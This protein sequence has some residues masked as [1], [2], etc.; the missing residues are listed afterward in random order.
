[1]NHI[2]K[3]KLERIARRITVATFKSRYDQKTKTK[4][5][6]GVMDSVGNRRVFV[7]ESFKRAWQSLFDKFSKDSPEA[8][9]NL[10][11]YYREGLKL[12]KQGTVGK[13]GN[14][15]EIKYLEFVPGKAQG[16]FYEYK[17]LYIKGTNFCPR[18]LFVNVQGTNDSI[19]LDI[20]DKNGNSTSAPVLSA[21]SSK[22]KAA[23]QNDYQNTY[24]QN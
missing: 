12:I 20:I 19:L 22:F 17:Q 5:P 2:D 18:I 4:V 24:S 8:R 15:R 16:R 3:N 14:S 6:A 9:K 7:S 23:L 10:N 1:M 13:A 11:E 21:L